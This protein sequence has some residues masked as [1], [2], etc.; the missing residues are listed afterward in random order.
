[1]SITAEGI[2]QFTQ[3]V[4]ALLLRI[5]GK[6]RHAISEIATEAGLSHHQAVLLMYMHETGPSTMGEL[7]DFIGS[8]QGVLT[9]IVDKL[10]DK[11]M[12][13]RQRDAT[14]RRVVKVSLS[15]RGSKL[16]EE[17]TEIRLSEV[18]RFSRML[19]DEE[20]QFFL[21]ILHKLEKQLED[22]TRVRPR[23]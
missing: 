16:A 9:R 8:T 17:M 5:F 12:I 11:R 3:E 7:S 2:N 22:S 13:R 15:P 19:Q 18:A 10:A 21:D 14:D 20:R 6:S 1:M 23:A 4:N